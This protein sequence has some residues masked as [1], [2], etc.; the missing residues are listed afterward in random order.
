MV[1]GNADLG[2]QPETINQDPY[3]AGLDHAHL[4]PDKAQF[5]GA[6]RREGHEAALAAETH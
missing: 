2:G 5:A 1:A 4:V 6:A 3:G